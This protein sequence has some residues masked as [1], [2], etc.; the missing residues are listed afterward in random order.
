[1]RTADDRF[2]LRYR[3]Y[4]DLADRLPNMLFIGRC[5]T[6]QYLDMDQVVAQS[7][8]GARRWLAMAG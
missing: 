7:L 5:G 1:V 3:A 2:Q 8:G 6:Y 4:R